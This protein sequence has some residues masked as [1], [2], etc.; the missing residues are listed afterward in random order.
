M[1]TGTAPPLCASWK[2]P[3]KKDSNHRRPRAA[4]DVAALESQTL[5]AATKPTPG[6]AKG[7]TISAR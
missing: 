7:L 4:H 1:L 3:W 2:A 6:S 5:G